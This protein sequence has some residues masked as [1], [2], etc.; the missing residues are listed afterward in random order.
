MQHQLPFMAHRLLT[1]VILVTTK[2]G[3]S[4]STDLIYSV[5]MGIY[6]PAK[7]PDLIT[8]SCRLYDFMECCSLT[9]LIALMRKY[10]QADIDKYRNANGNP[11]YPNT[12]WM[13]L[14]FGNAVVATHSLTCNGWE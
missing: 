12:N 13:D 9:I 5:N 8:N 4:G 11:L 6:Q 3:R 14:V 10:A 7:L 2:R 1:G